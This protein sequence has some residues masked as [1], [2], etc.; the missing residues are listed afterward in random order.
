MQAKQF[1]HIWKTS[2][3]SQELVL[4]RDLIASVFSSL[5]LFL[6]PTKVK[7]LMTIM[8]VEKSLKM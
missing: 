8:A 7:K 4:A 6:L 3:P 5:L 2:K 1:T